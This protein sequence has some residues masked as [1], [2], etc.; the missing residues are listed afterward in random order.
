MRIKKPLCLIE[1][2]RDAWQGIGSFI[3]TATKAEYI[4]TLLK[5]GVDIVEVGSFVSPKAIPQLSDTDQLLEMIEPAIEKTKLMVLVGNERGL[6]AALGHDKVSY[7]S[8]PFSISETF[9]KKNLNTSYKDALNF[10]EK[11]NNLC[12]QT[13]KEPILYI[14]MAFGNPY[15][16]S[17][18]LNKLSDSVDNIVEL[19]I[20][21]I[22]LT[23]IVGNAS[24]KTIEEVYNHLNNKYQHIDF[25]LHLHASE[26]WQRKVE[27]AY[28]NN[29][30]MF[31]SVIHGYGGCPM[32]GKQMIGNV[33]T[34]RLLLYFEQKGEK[35]IEID[36]LELRKAEIM[37][38]EIFNAFH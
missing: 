8:Y 20:T 25:G 34:L 3:P 18:S 16:D 21:K 28:S 12:R 33:D 31:D 9:L 11:A 22:T 26:N 5:I 13:G 4:N 6:E 14:T 32:T 37:S 35:L 7:I 10:I 29:C 27:A 15:G 2:P 30:R 23:D 19:G 24:D 36:N 38:A 17:W 1:S